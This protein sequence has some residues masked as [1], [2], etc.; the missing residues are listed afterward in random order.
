M[1]TPVP[2][3]CVSL[4][5][6]RFRRY[7]DPSSPLFTHYYLADHTDDTMDGKRPMRQ[8]DGGLLLRQRSTP[9]L[10]VGRARVLTPR[11]QHNPHLIMLL[12]VC[13]SSCVW[14]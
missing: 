13:L 11:P 12:C 8:K 1:A 4:V 7:V 10:P 5:A 6:G 9:A 2:A 3:K 14:L